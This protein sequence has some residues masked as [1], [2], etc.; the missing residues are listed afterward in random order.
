MPTPAQGARLVF[1]QSIDGPPLGVTEERYQKTGET[2]PTMR[3]PSHGAVLTLSPIGES[4]VEVY[5]RS[6]HHED[7]IVRVHGTAALRDDSNKQLAA[8][9]DGWWTPM[10][11]GSGD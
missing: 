5:R 4:S 1:V 2:K 6:P 7:V 8:L 11:I 10:H 3:S 9:G